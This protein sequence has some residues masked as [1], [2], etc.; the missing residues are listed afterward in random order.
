MLKPPKILKDSLRL[1]PSEFICKADSH[2]RE[3]SADESNISSIDDMAGYFKNPL[4]LNEDDYLVSQEEQKEVISYEF[5]LSKNHTPLGSFVQLES[6]R[7][8]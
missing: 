2:I 6:N 1:P 5:P 7:N 8:I 3:Q 4:D